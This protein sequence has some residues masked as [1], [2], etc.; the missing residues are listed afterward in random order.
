M[1]KKLDYSC[2][3]NIN[4]IVIIIKQNNTMINSNNTKT[5][6]KY[7]GRNQTKCPLQGTC[8]EENVL[9]QAKK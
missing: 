4:E 7:N 2:T 5:M 3:Y 8:R 1:I 9:Y 6:T